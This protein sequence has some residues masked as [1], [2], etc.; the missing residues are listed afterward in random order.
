MRM[1]DPD[2]SGKDLPTRIGKGMLI[3][4]WITGLAVLLLFF[5]GIVNEQRN[6]NRSPEV[7]LSEGGAPQVVLRRNR[8]G[9]YVAKGTI[10]GL[11]VTFLI[12]TGAT[13]VALPIE[14][15]RRLDL[16]LRPGGQTRT[17]NGDVLTWSTTLESIDLGGLEVR[18]VRALVLP[19][20]PGNQ[21]LLGMSYLRRF[22]LTQ[23][24][25][26]LILRL[27]VP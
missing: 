15:A 26:R 23:R 11:P 20:L 21:V 25:D 24:D 3:G 2:S 4:A 14:L 10:D 8:A 13:L 19:N 18:H 9:H 12:D 7:N 17:A 27:I 16:R 22:E 6:P 1:T 5:Q